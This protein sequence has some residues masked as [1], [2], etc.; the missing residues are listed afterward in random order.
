MACGD[1]CVFTNN[2]TSNCGYCDTVCTDVEFCGYGGS[3]INC[4]DPG[5]GPGWGPCPFINEGIVDYFCTDLGSDG[6]G[7]GCGTCGYTCP[8]DTPSCN[9]GTCAQCPIG[10]NAEPDDGMPLGWACFPDTV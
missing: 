10:Y 1:N 8:D 5:W 7:G 6:D 4:D 2:D 9:D 3:C